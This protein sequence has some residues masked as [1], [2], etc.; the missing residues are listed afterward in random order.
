MKSLLVDALRQKDEDRDGDSLSDSG[1]FATPHADRAASSVHEAETPDGPDD[2]ELLATGA[3]IVANDEEPEKSGVAED[4][5]FGSDVT[6][7]EPTE[8]IAAES[9]PL[10]LGEAFVPA[11]DSLPS[12]PPVARYVPAVCVAIALF[13][14][15]TWFGFL[16]LELQE[17]R[18]LLGSSTSALRSQTVVSENGIAATAPRF[19]YLGLDGQPLDDEAWQ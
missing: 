5:H 8:T 7:V 9:A 18:S 10:A 14:A 17:G 16:Q 11:H 1:S 6:K 3:F 2:L 15:L 12:M 19:R 13:A 4:D